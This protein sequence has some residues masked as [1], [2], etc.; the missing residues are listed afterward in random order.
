LQIKVR[1][2]AARALF[3]VAAIGTLALALYPRLQ[4]PEPHVIA[5]YMQY[6]YHAIAFFVLTLL[7]AVSWGLNWRLVAV[8][9][10][11]SR[12]AGGCADAVART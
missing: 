9:T 7:G 8:L 12:S 11:S 2:Q 10:A 6:G 4:L 1:L 5:D 3:C